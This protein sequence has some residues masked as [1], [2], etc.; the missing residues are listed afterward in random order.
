MSEILLLSG[1]EPSGASIP[2]RPSLHG[3]GFLRPSGRRLLSIRGPQFG[4]VP[5]LQ[6][7]F[8]FGID[9]KGLSGICVTQSCDEPR[10]VLPV[11]SLLDIAV[12]A[13]S[14]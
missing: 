7:D 2:P 1:V 3:R 4:R 8:W 11:D 12:A 13:Y 6:R 9:Q 10:P 14:S 5:S